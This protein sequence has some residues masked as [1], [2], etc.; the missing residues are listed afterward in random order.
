MMNDDKHVDRYVRITNRERF[1]IEYALSLLEAYD[2]YGRSLPHTKEVIAL[3]CVFCEE[4][5][6]KEYY[7]RHANK[8]VSVQTMW[9]GDDDDVKRIGTREEYQEGGEE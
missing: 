3:S 8:V 9:K 6:I 5:W 4:N 7:I 2:K 1:L